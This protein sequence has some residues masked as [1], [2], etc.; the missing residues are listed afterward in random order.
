MS[1][2]LG[3]FFAPW[4]IPLIGMLALSVR[5]RAWEVPCIGLLMDVLWYAPGAPY[6]PMCALVGVMLVWVFEPFR[7]R[8]MVGY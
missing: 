4:W 6:P 3:V 2:V 1:C 7:T 8:C 5:F